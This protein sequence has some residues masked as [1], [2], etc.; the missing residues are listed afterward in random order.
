MP[1]STCGP[2]ADEHVGAVV[3]RLVREFD[4]EVGRLILEQPLLRR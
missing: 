1:R 4:Q 3:D 2:C